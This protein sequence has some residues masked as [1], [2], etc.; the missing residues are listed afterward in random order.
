M[1]DSLTE[2]VVAA[3]GQQ[4]QV[5]SE[6]G[7][8]G[9]SV[10]YRARDIRLNRIVAIKV[11]PP[12]LAYDPAIRTRFT[13]EAQTSAQ[14][15]HAHI[16]PI[17]DVGER[18]GIAYFV[19]ALVTGGNLAA[20]L[21]REPRQ[22][23]EEVRRLL[24]EIADALAYAHLRG[25]IHRDVKPDNILLD[26]DS[27]RAIVTDFGI[28]RAIEAGTRL[29]ITGNA[30]GTPQYMSPEQAVGEREVDGRSDIYSLG[31]VAYQMLTGRLPFSGANTMAL[32]LK[33]VNERPLPIVELRPDA[34]K[35]LRDAIE[36]ALM[37]APEDRWPT[38]A[39]MRQA[40]MSDDAG[41]SWRAEAREQVRYTSPKP[42]GARRD[43][44]SREGA[45]GDVRLVSPRRGSPA[46][47]GRGEN[48]VP[49]LVGDMVVVPDQ[50]AALTPAQRDDLRLWHGRIELLERVRA[51]RGYALYTSVMWVAGVTGFVNG[52]I[53]GIPPLV[54][55]P[56][57][58]FLMSVKLARRGRSLRA[59]GLKLRRTFLKLRSRWVLP[60]PPPAP[61]Q[62]QL[63][64]LAPREVLESQYGP[65]IRRAV[66]DRAA[67]MDIVSKLSKVDRALL[68]DIDPAVKGLVERV[69]QLAQMTYR[70]EQSIDLRLLN[71]LNGR[72]AEMEDEPSSPES[73]RRLS[74][75]QRQRTTLEELVQRRATLARQLDNAGLALGS[76]RLDLIKFR[77]SGLES[78]LSDVSSATREA[79]ALSKEIGAAL[80][81]AAEVKGL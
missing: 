26:A 48:V 7:R 52:V 77:S 6:I 40:I 30:L 11:L 20:L 10:V 23:I 28:A 24:C 29:T 1:T 21:A 79:R 44:Q 55:A 22:P 35:P 72:I 56:V 38:A 47:P 70:L 25:V 58:P 9:M 39:S 4:Y 32:L 33:H 41:P 68:P 8:G 63:L 60:A 15:S 13:R 50:L 57:I 80:E 31:V 62:Q 65:A 43:R 67:I 59:S 49:Q 17:Y 76:L 73:Q 5:E 18:E 3:L 66:E 36:R 37:K 81:A 27:G 54:V 78:A 42:E 71:E 14:L 74:L 75:L 34:P 12:E 16:V 61:K 2:R 51:F 53:E 64:K 45:R 69:A 19:M 46:A